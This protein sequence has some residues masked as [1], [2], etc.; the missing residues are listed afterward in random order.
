[1]G[2]YDPPL[3]RDGVQDDEMVE[4]ARAT[5]GALSTELTAIFDAWWPEG[6][7]D[8]PLSR[9]AYLLSL[10]PMHFYTFHFSWVY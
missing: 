8:I 6:S 10:V 9:R 2:Y 5:L 3:S 4:R 1:M 7:R